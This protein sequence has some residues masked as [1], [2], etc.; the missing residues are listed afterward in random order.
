MWKPHTPRTH[1]G[2]MLTVAVVALVMA[3][4]VAGCAGGGA[5]DASGTNPT[6]SANVGS[7]NGKKSSGGAAPAWSQT[8]SVNQGRLAFCLPEGADNYSTEIGAPADGRLNDDTG[9]MMWVIPA[10]DGRIGLSWT[11]I[12]SEVYLTLTEYMRWSFVGSTNGNPDTVTS[13]NGVHAYYY[14]AGRDDAT[15]E[16]KAGLVVFEDARYQ[17]RF[18]VE[19]GTTTSWFWTN[20][21]QATLSLFE[22]VVL[23]DPGPQPPLVVDPAWGN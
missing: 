5:Q 16:F 2:R 9:M 22:C 7:N 21:R 10:R 17:Y 6:S 12:G 18:S 14:D 23:S 13:V 20:H 3:L 15:G 11:R 19:G 8:V 4:T 1:V